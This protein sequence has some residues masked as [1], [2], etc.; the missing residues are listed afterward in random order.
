MGWPTVRTGARKCICQSNKKTDFNPAYI[1]KHTHKHT[2]SYG[3]RYNQLLHSISGRVG[4]KWMSVWQTESFLMS[5]FLSDIITHTHSLTHIRM[6]SHKNL[7]RNT[8]KD[9]TSS[10]SNY[11]PLLLFP[12]KGWRIIHFQALPSPYLSHSVSFSQMHWQA[13]H[14]VTV[15]GERRNVG[16]EILLHWKTYTELQGW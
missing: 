10:T 15:A 6:H 4:L 1:Y 5:H 14:L 12:A 9:D 7:H 13:I 16:A 2:R 8:H 3:H 11:H